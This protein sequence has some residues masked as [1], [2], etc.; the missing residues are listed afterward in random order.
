M[1][2]YKTLIL[3]LLLI[4]TLIFAQTESQKSALKKMVETE[5]A[6]AQTSLD[7]GTKDTFLE[8]LSNDAIVF[9]KGT[10]INGLEYWQ[11][12][13]F[14]NLMI[15]QP[16]FAEITV[17][18]ELGYTLEN[19]QVRSLAIDNRPISY[20]TSFSLWKKQTDGNWKIAVNFKVNHPEINP[21]TPLIKESFAT[22]KPN[23]LKNTAVLAERMVFMND[24]FYW[25]N[26][27]T[28]LNPFEPHL[29]Q[30]IKL[31]RNNVLPILGREAAKN[32]LKKTHDKAIV[33]TGLKAIPS[34]AGDIVCVYG[35]ISGKGKMGEYVRI[36]KQESKD[37]WKIVVEMVNMN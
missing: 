30:D 24:F 16:T 9:D 23:E 4:P 8:F 2:F 3:G 34:Q 35:V 22:F 25:K 21:V 5:K 32:Y 19:F 11:K 7:K 36:W 13:D 15:W 6:F 37:V 28:S 20:G 31:Y 10:A 26:A 18:E 17:S 29:S 12:L 14:K 27:K 33:Y 1:T